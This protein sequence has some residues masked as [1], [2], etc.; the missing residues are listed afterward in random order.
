MPGKIPIK[1]RGMWGFIPFYDLAV[2]N[3]ETQGDGGGG[4]A[5]EITNMIE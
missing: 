2:S 4:G 3:A 1:G 5:K